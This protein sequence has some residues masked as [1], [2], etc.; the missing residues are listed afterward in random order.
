MA[1]ETGRGRTRLVWLLSG[2]AM[3]PVAAALAA[4]GAADTAG[5]SVPAGTQLAQ[6]EQRSFAIPAQPLDGALVAFGAASGMQV[7]YDSALTANLRSPGVSGLLPPREALARLLAGTGL[8][9]RFTGARAATLTRP[10]PQEEGGLQD[11]GSTRLPPVVAVGTPE[12]GWSP[13][14]GFVAGVTAT[15]TKTDTPILEVPQSISVV[16]RDQMDAQGSS[17][18]EEAV[19]YTAGVRVG[20]Y[21][22]DSRVDEIQVRGFRTGSFAN[23]LYIDGLRPPGSSSGASASATQFEAYGL[24]RAE[25]MRGPASI[26]YGQVA[27]GGM[28]NVV[29]K[30]PTATP[31]GEVMAVGGSYE[32]ARFNGDIS[33]PLDGDGKFLYRLVGV[34]YDSDTQVDHVD[35]QRLFVAPS[36]TWQ[37]QDGTSLTVRL[38]YQRDTGGSTFQFLPA[39]GTLTPNPDGL[40]LSTSSFLGE[41][42]FNRYDRTQFMAS[43]QFEH[44]INEVFTLR[45]NLA[46]TNVETLNSGVS[47]SGNV[48]ADGMTYRRTSSSNW[49][50]GTGF[51]VDTS[52]QADFGTGPLRHKLL[53]GIDYRTSTIDVDSASGTASPLNIFYPVYGGPISIGPRTAANRQVTEQT[54]VYLQDQ[55]RLGNLIVTLGGRQDWAR[56]QTRN[57][58]THV[59]T[60]YDSDAFTWRGGLTYLFDM[61]LALYASYSESFEPTS[62]RD[63]FDNPFKPITGQQYEAGIKYQPPGHQSLVTLA[64]YQIKQQNIT[65]P[66]P[67]PTHL[68]D[69]STCRVQTGEGRVRGIELEAHVQITDA[70]RLIGSYTYMQSEVTR[71]NSTDLGKRLPMVPRQMAS[72]WLDYRFAEGDTLDGLSL[73]TGIRYVGGTYGDTT[74]TYAVPSYTLW[75][76][77]IRYDLGRLA[78]SMEGMEL[79]VSG[80]NLAD[81]VYLATCSGNCYF[82]PRR[83]V[84]A[85]LRYRW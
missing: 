57:P 51:A 53:A 65:T 36:V 75:D 58:R 82:A 29:T 79:A 71:S 4:G 54:G 47:R 31:R 20:S 74:N 21:G 27:P 5:R 78:P 69:G 30:R 40:K 25:V 61:G 19:R 2:A 3:L 11:D 8:V 45:Q 56:N 33:G 60:D 28:I 55:M 17:T 26:L 49:I 67:D 39:V 10:A 38:A 35:R 50:R 18:T 15:G 81:K 16:T 13:V 66:D 83:M 64:A 73:G 76:A 77:S 1:F 41:P 70:L 59:G 80:T 14:R 43:Y 37:P 52:G 84:Q 6:A 48:L 63:Y 42:D 34:A 44:R 46:Y 62:G 24:E 12:R 23:N 22:A 85:S 9:P 68:C 72:G 32:Q 7:L